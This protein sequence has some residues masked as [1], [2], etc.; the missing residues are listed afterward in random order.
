VAPRILGV[1]GAGKMSKSMGNFIA[2][3]EDEKVMWEKL[4]TAVTDVNR[5]RRKDTGN[6]DICNIYTIHRAFSSE[7][8]CIEV[9]EGCRTAAI[10]C[11]D[12]KKM[13]FENMR[14]ELAP[15]QEKAAALMS[16]TGYVM[17]VLKKGADECRVIAKQTMEEVHQ[18]LGLL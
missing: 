4:R 9:A 1:D 11:I 14:K 17:D 10:G 16:D 5:V 3:L 2:I 18:A 15:I 6:P 7:E 8:L 13:L 12:C